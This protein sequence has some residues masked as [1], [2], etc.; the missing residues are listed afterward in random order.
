MPPKDAYD[1]YLSYA[2]EANGPILE[3]M[4]GTGRFLLPLLAAGFKIEGF[5]AS[6]ATHSLFQFAFLKQS[7]PN[8]F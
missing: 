5:D 8:R 7:E 2:K 1:F 4:C 6:E 3:P